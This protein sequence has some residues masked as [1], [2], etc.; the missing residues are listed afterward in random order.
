[1]N[2]RNIGRGVAAVAVAYAAVLLGVHLW[3]VGHDVVR[4][5]A[6]VAAASTDVFH[7]SHDPWRVLPES[8][9]LA[10]SFIA[11]WLLAA[12]VCVGSLERHYGSLVT[13][14][15]A[16]AGHLIGTGVSEGTVAVRVAIGDLPHHSVHLLDVGPSYVVVACGTAAAATPGLRRWHRWLLVLVLAPFAV[17]SIE[18]LPTGEVDAIGHLTAGLVG[19]GAAAVLKRWAPKPQLPMRPQRAAAEPAAR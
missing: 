3:L 8:A 2:A 6:I 14:A 4:R 5:G 12:L 18:G 7:L 19:L 1:M 13:A 16:I 15:V 17:Q 9:V 10:R 11:L